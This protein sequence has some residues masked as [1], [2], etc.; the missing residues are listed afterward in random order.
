MKYAYCFVTISPVRLEAKDSSE[1]VTQ[2]LFGEPVTI[3]EQNGQW[4][5]IQTMLD[6]YVGFCDIKHLKFLSFKEFRNWMDGHGFL[7]NES[8]LLATPWGRQNIVRGSIIPQ[9]STVDF[10]VGKD[11]FSFVVTPETKTWGNVIHAASSYINAPYLWGGKS[12]F[13]IDCS[14]FTQSVLR[15]FDVNIPRDASQQIEC[16]QP[17]NFEERAAG[18]LSFFNNPATGKII[19]VGF[20]M[21]NDKIIHASGRVRIDHLDSEGIKNSETGEQTHFLHSIRRL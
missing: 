6:G 5:K 1:M 20:C 19:H 12:P 9:S 4:A 10:Q 14:G 21:E 8:I 18:D 17:V 7:E 15:F 3:E 2:L 13:G 16:G 11:A